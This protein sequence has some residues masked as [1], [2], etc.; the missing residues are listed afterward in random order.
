MIFGRRNLICLFILLLLTAS[1]VAQTN[2]TK[3][4]LS[5]NAT[6]VSVNQTANMNG[7]TSFS[8]VE[9]DALSQN[10]VQKWECREFSN[11]Q[12]Y[13][14]CYYDP[15]ISDCRCYA[16]DISLCK[17]PDLK[18]AFEYECKR[19]EIVG[20]YN[21]D[22]TF[23][24][25]ENKCQC[26]TGDFDLCR[27]N[28]SNKREVVF[29]SANTIVNITE[30]ANETINTTETNQTGNQSMEPAKTVSPVIQAST[31]AIIIAV[32]IAIYLIFT[33]T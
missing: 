29:P 17:N 1:A 21:F 26:F 7:S 11:N 19:S 18:C 13:Y 14:A 16:G 28:I 4:N 9:L 6:S 31:I 20:G 3:V 32:V 24:R 23:D 2:I 10:C 15:K 12:H 22:C 25:S 33:F 8:K 5:S 30:P 27:Y